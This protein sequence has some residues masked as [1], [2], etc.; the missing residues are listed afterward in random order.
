MVTP[1]PPPE[2]PEPDLLDDREW[3]DAH[4]DESSKELS[5]LVLHRARDDL[6]D[7]ILEPGRPPGGGGFAAGFFCF[8]S[9]R[10]LMSR[11]SSGVMFGHFKTGFD[12]SSR[13]WRCTAARVE[14]W[15]SCSH[16]M[17]LN[18]GLVLSVPAISV[19]N[20]DQ[21]C[22]GSGLRLPSF[23]GASAALGAAVRK[24]SIANFFGH[25]PENSAIEP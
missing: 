6:L 21:K 17:H 9:Y 4:E 14:P 12:G 18:F 16:V 5:D 11:A 15:N 7:P 19:R 24:P 13:A 25:K 20:P 22:S 2:P 3:E 10:R 8:V 1:P 23:F